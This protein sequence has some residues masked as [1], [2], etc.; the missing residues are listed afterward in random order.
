MTPFRLQSCF[1][2]FG[3]ERSTAW[4]TTGMSQHLILP[5]ISVPTNLLHLTKLIACSSFYA[6]SSSCIIFCLS[7]HHCSTRLLCMLATWREIHGLKAG[8][9]AL[10]AL[11]WLCSSFVRCNI[12]GCTCF[13][14]ACQLPDSLDHTHGLCSW[15]FAL[16]PLHCHDLLL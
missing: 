13:V 7:Q 9:S 8:P 3:L 1:S 16:L 12:A 5:A 15:T 2:S 14:K 4:Q 6:H 10:T 11:E